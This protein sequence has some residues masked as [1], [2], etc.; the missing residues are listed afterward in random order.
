MNTFFKPLFQRL[1][2]VVFG[3]FALTCLF[4]AGELWASETGS[5]RWPS[6]QEV[7]K[8]WGNVPLDAIEHAAENNDPTAE[9]YL[10]YCYAQ[11]FRFPR[12]LEKGISWYEKAGK[13]GYMPSFNNLGLLY[14]QGN[15]VPQD[16]SKM[17]YY[18][19]LAADGGFAR[20]QL[21]LSCIY[22]EGSGVQRDLN[23]AGKWLA[24]VEESGDG[25]VQCAVGFNYEHPGYNPQSPQWINIREAARWY[26]LAANQNDAGGQYYLGLCYLEG[27]G[28]EQ[29]EERGLDL[30]RRAADQN[31]LHA[32]ISLANL[33]D[34][35]V[36][37]PRDA[38]DQPLQILERAVQTHPHE[39]G[40]YSSLVYWYEFKLGNNRDLMAAVQWYCRGALAGA[41]NYSLNPEIDLGAAVC[42]SLSFSAASAPSILPDVG[43]P[44]KS[45]MSAYLKAA[46]LND[47]QALRHIGEMY[48]SGDDVPVS[49]LDA[50]P[51]L[52]LAAQKGDSWAVD[53]VAQ[54]ESNMTR[55]ELDA[56]KKQLP[57]LV[58]ELN[59]VACAQSA[60]P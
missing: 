53:K 29:D 49:A 20:A 15:G 24:K 28:V 16:Y 46:R 27:K 1:V 56:A 39:G 26:G 59:A 5:H 48:L 30:I 18:Y 2:P 40:P 9:H 13:M 50:W 36:G 54:I 14:Q 23:E 31:D 58:Q 3:A 21:N 32:M 52:T 60:A 17:L 4:G 25:A 41:S 34:Q 11:G 22:R 43:G 44:L 19:R 57:S 10:G 6:L 38:K 47:V 12:D 45:V 51:W 8:K 55:S 37:E 33:Y 42:Y 35:G 7:L